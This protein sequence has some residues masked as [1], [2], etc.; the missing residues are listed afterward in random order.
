M[1]AGIMEFLCTALLLNEIHLTIN[2]Q[3]KVMLLKNRD[4]Q[5]DD[6]ITVSPSSVV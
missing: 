2:L 3:V 6:L 5:M 1:P 4:G